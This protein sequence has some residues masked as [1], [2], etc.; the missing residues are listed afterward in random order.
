MRPESVSTATNIPL[1]CSSLFS[2]FGCVIVWKPDC[3]TTRDRR[4][5]HVP[6][7]SSR[8]WAE[9][10]YA[11]TRIV[12]QYVPRQAGEKTAFAAR[13]S[14]V[15][16]SSHGEWRVSACLPTSMRPC[17]VRFLA[18]VRLCVLFLRCLKIVVAAGRCGWQSS[19]SLLL[20]LLF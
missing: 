9:L 3:F 20:L 16:A 18:R 10:E 17:V 5:S 1:E 11:R 15:A 7:G 2:L 14:D 4:G 6:G 12:N 13:I 8:C 19:G